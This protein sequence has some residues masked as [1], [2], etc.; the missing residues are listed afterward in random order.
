MRHQ[1]NIL[2]LQVD[3]LSASALRAYGNRCS[4]T[5]AIDRLAGAGLVFENAYTNFPVCASSRFSMMSGRLASAIEAFDNAAEFR[6][7]VPTMAHYLRHLDYQTTL[8][9]KMH[10]IGPDLLHGFEERLTPEI[11][12]S[13]FM[14]LPDWSE[15]ERDDYASDAY[16]ALC[17]A[18]PAPRTVQIDYDEEVAFQAKRKLYDLARTDDPRSFLLVVSFTHPHDPY[19]CRQEFWDLFS[20]AE[21]D[22]PRVGRFAKSDLD[23]HSRRIYRHYNLS[24]PEITDDHVRRARRAYYGSLAYVD[25]YLG[26]LLDVARETGLLDDTIVVFTSDHGD[27]LG[28]RGMWFKKVLFENAMRVPLILA[29]P[30]IPEGRI[31]ENVSLVDLMPTFVDAARA[32]GDFR[33]LGP[34]D[35]HSLWP[36][37]EGRS[38]AWPNTVHGEMTCEGVIEPV[39]MIRRGSFKFICSS[40][41]DPLLFDLSRDPDE[42][43]DL[44]GDGGVVAIE[45][46]FRRLVDEK[47]GD[48]DDLRDRI[49]ASQRTRKLVRSA[50]EKGRYR[51]WDDNETVGDG[52]RYLRYGKSYNAW[53]YTGV[54]KL[55]GGLAS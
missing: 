51:S 47:W 22:M 41:T 35:G 40:S 20:D 38:T 27:M 13:D 11:Y 53:N 31:S 39:V 54:E 16:E 1:P 7:S 9:G 50:L 15:S 5:P 30:G 25:R 8:C 46:D 4:I 34:L 42:L 2:M 29:G 32:G 18:G 10:F 23:P 48:L 21:I 12:S 17:E 3:Q 26:E 24:R 37:I 43:V 6:A 28:E 36:L 44:A 55:R 33:C 49:V 14:T 52:D 45:A 19:I